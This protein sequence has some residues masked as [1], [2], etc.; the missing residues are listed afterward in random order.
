METKI[1]A[2]TIFTC[3]VDLFTH[4]KILLIG[5]HSRYP[6]PHPTKTVQKF[7]LQF[8]SSSKITIGQKDHG[9][10]MSLTHFQ[11]HFT[12]FS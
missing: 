8:F 12:V 4:Q 6:F 5:M 3:T 9:A 2:C 11:C 1:R 10:T 7:L